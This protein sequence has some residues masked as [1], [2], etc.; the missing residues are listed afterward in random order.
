[1][2]S[3]YVIQTKT[4]P[5]RFQPI[6]KS[7]IIAWEEGCLKCAV[8]VKRECIYRVYENR[9]LDVRQMIDSVDNQCMNC[10]I[11]VQNCPKELIHKSINPE[12]LA[13]G[14]SYWSPDIISTLWNQAK[15][16]KIPVS[17]AGYS[18]PFS[19][20]GF[21][22]MWT[23]MSE[24]VRPTR[25]G[26]HGREY[27]STAVDIGGAPK[28]LHFR[29]NGEMEGGYPRLIDIPLPI[30]IRMPS[31]G[32]LSEKTFRGWAMAAALL[33]A[34]LAI[35]FEKIDR[36]M[37]DFY[38]HLMPIVSSK[39]I[40]TE[41]YEKIR[42]VEILWGKD[43]KR[44]IRTVNE[45]FPTAVVCVRLPM[46]YGVEEKTLAIVDSGCDVIHLEGTSNGRSKDDES[47]FVKDIIREVHLTLVNKGIRDGISILASGGFAMAEH[48]AKA[49]LCGAD[50][51]FAD[52]PILIA[53]ECRMCRLCEHGLSCPVEIETASSKWVA[54]RTINMLGAWHNQLLEVM[55]AMGIR[56]IRR[57]RGEAGR[58]IFF[59]EIDRET[60]GSLCDMEKGFEL[61]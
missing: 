26:I 45:F 21:D 20:T 4:V 23:D 28:N 50:A 41:K 19:G 40:L 35:P 32:S 12:F 47:R 6:A 13:M 46:E 15:T 55:G 5:H 33:G 58:A 17:G 14:D 44:T 54:S 43:F 22:S 57:L 48:V 8:C 56:D 11:C 38:Y 10:F 3:K 7:G 42:M 27:I 29:N 49:I 53:L 36:G 1:M 30:I 25:D 34:L 37:K 31:F 9:G 2:Q 52:F 24:I 59:E 51:V 61:E 39:T 60:F 18:G 16:G